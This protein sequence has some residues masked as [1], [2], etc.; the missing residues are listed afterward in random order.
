MFPGRGFPRLGLGWVST[1]WWSARCPA[2]TVV[3]CTSLMFKPWPRNCEPV[4]TRPTRIH[5][6]NPVLP[7]S[8]RIGPL[9]QPDL[10]AGRDLAT[11]DVW[12]NQLDVDPER[13]SQLSRC[14]S[15]EEHARA[16]RFHFE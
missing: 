15:T 14:L 12:H 7:A 1:T 11:V 8:S 6:S 16:A 3:S 10:L 5:G 4:W 2:S 9:H 13:L